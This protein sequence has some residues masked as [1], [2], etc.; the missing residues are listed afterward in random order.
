MVRRSLVPASAW[1]KSTQKSLQHRLPVDLAV[2]DLVELLFEL[3]GEVVADVFGEEGFEER[4]DE[5]ALVLGDQPLLLD[6]HIVAVA[7]HGERRG[8]GRGSAD[9]E[10]LHPLDQRR[11]GVARRRLGEVLRRLDPLLGQRLARR[12]RRQPRRIL[13]LLVVAPFLIEREE[14]GE[15]NDLAAGAEFELALARFGEDVDGGALELGALH[16]AGERAVPDQLVELG[17][18]GLEAARDVARPDPLV[19]RA[20]RLVRFLRVLRLDRVAARR[21]GH[22]GVAEIL[23]DDGARGGD[24][25]RREV[26]AVGAHIGDEAG[27]AFADVDAFIEALGDLHRA[28]RREAELAARLLLQRRGG[29]GRVGVALLRLRLDGRDAEARGFERRLERLRLGARTDVEAVDLLAVGADEARGERRAGLGRQMGDDRPVF[30]RDEF[31][32][33]DLAVADDP[34][35]RPTARGPAERA[36]GSLRHSTGERLKPTR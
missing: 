9:A 6:P 29:E 7:Q 34:A 1:E 2:G 5:A 26:D 28:R 21:G 15:A 23:G 24:R 17:L 16:L 8:V 19:G 27:G 10:L 33:L 4:G 30:A 14:A 25:L 35:A 3:G 13:V 31:L 32:D 20:N 11:F 12:H 22:V 18:V 36:P